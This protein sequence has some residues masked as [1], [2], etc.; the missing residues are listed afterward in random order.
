METWTEKLLSKLKIKNYEKFI[1]KSR[2]KIY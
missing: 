2:K 1:V